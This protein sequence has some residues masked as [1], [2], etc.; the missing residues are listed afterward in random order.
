MYCHMEDVIC[1]VGGLTRIA[2]LN[3]TNQRN[4]CPDSLTTY[5]L[6]GKRLCVG[7]VSGAQFAS[8][9]YHTYHMN[10]N[11]VCGRAIGYANYGPHA[12]HYSTALYKSIDQPYVSG[13]SITYRIRDQRK[14]IWTLA[15]GYGDPGNARTYNCPCAGKSTHNPP[16]FVNDD[17]YCESGSHASV[18][19]KWY[20][21]NPLWDGQG[22][23]SSSR[24]CGNSRLPW[25]WRTL[26]DTTNSD[27][28]VRWM[29]PQGHGTGIVG[30]EQ[31]ELYVY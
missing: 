10:Y 6:S 31:L 20:L 19:R 23:H 13:L 30:I 12:F 22:C 5:A 8:V 28:E 24:C 1:G 18:S 7:P 26:P 2:N 3:M 27:I 11:F 16:Y 25:F 9:S 29:D 14:H 4:R 15:A 17:H 21:D